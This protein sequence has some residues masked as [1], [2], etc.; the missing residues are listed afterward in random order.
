[1]KWP[2]WLRW[3]AANGNGGGN[4]GLKLPPGFNPPP[5]WYPRRNGWEIVSGVFEWAENMPRLSGG[6]P[7]ASYGRKRRGRFPAAK[8]NYRSLRGGEEE[9]LFWTAD[10]SGS[11]EWSLLN[12]EGGPQSGNLLWFSIDGAT[13]P[14]RPEAPDCA[15]LPP[16]GTFGC[17]ESRKG[18][19]EISICAGYEVGSSGINYVLFTAQRTTPTPVWSVNAK[20]EPI[21]LPVEPG[22]V[23]DETRSETIES[24]PAPVEPEKI[25]SP[26][27]YDR[28]IG[29]SKLGLLRWASWVSAGLIAV[30][31]VLQVLLWLH[32]IR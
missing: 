6:P 4:G 32:L 12:V 22:N 28:P 31:W 14:A 9:T 25:E 21:V 26:G 1:M 20:S 23:T 7:A 5:H 18:L 13:I 24:K 19:N 17:G 3:F 16:G 2:K 10:P 11:T 27:A 15:F 8:L 29:V 30:G